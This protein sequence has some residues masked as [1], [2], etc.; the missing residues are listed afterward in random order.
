VSHVTRSLMIAEREFD[1]F[2]HLIACY[3]PRPVAEAYLRLRSLP[4]SRLKSTGGI[5][6]IS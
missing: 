5:L 2:R 1:H 3:R 4:A 6:V